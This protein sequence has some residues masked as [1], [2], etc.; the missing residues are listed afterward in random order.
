MSFDA[1]RVDNLLAR[2]NRI[3]FS[4]ATIGI[5][6]LLS[7][8]WLSE[9]FDIGI[10]GPVITVL[11]TTWGLSKSELGILGVSSTLGVVLGMLPAGYLA[12]RIGRKTIVLYGITLFSIVTLMG[13]FVH[14]LWT[15]CA[16]RFFA[17]IGEGA[18]LPM[19]YLY[20]AEFVR[21]RRRAVSVGF[22]N[23]ILTA[24]YLLPN[25]AGAWAIHAFPED[26]AWRVPFLMGVIPLLILI[27][28]ALWLPESPRFLL[29]R[30]ETKAVAQIVLRLERSAGIAPDDT[31]VSHENDPAD[32]AELDQ[33]FVKLYVYRGL[34]VMAQLTGALILFYILLNYGATMMIA[35]GLESSEALLYTGAMMLIAGVGS[36][37]QG[38]LAETFGRKPVLLI[39]YVLAAAGCLLFGLFTSIQ[40]GVI[41]ALL[42]AFF[43]LGVFPVAKVC[44]PEQFPNPFRG[45]AVYYV[46]MTARLLSG[47]ITLYFIPFLLDLWGTQLIYVAMGIA[48]FVLVLPFAFWGRE[49]S[50][51]SIEDATLA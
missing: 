32:T 38:F 34:V 8:V 44:V 7:L 14:S 26:V 27:P 15:L 31:L 6:T 45:R 19:P 12:D 2:L 29:K 5:I 39:Y 17:G 11:H 20:L 1:L 42:A 43:G 35:R 36:I 18:V 23:G 13:A 25:L 48:L 50:N 41:G 46:E 16:V 22:A 40:M 21:I 51:L 37:V 33:P 3:P 24:A 49:T 4:R 47:V 10:V 28:L 30:G 9:A